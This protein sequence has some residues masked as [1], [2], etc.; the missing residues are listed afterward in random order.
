MF[1]HEALHCGD[2]VRE[3]GGQFGKAK[4]A[5]DYDKPEAAVQYCGPLIRPPTDVRVIGR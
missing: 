1:L 4:L 2:R 3:V 5:N